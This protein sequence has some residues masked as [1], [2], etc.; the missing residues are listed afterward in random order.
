MR[1]IFFIFTTFFAINA[2]AQIIEKELKTTGSLRILKT[3]NI[4]DTSV[5]TNYF[6]CNTGSHTPKHPLII[7]DGKRKRFKYINK[8]SMSLVE[9]ILVLERVEAKEKYG[10]KA[11]HGA[12]VIE[13]K[14]T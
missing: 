14:K 4:S 7:I 6:H 5:R 13:M 12:V 11:K 9:S 3:I 10:R 1:K 2:S 8:L